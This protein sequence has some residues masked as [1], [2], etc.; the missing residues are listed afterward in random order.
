VVGHPARVVRY[1]FSDEII[2][3]L[4]EEQWWE[5]SL[6]ELKSEGLEQFQVPLEGELLR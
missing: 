6:D 4:L 1:R 2:E 5:K 3:Q